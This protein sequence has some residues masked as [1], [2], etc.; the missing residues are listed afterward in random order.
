VE[1]TAKRPKLCFFIVEPIEIFLLEEMQDILQS[2]AFS[3]H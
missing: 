2:I 1:E 3:L